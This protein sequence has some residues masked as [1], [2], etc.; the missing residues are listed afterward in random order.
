MAGRTATDEVDEPTQLVNETGPFDLGVQGSGSTE[1]VD[2]SKEDKMDCIMLLHHV[3]MNAI[4]D[5][6][7]IPL[8][9]Q[10]AVTK[11][12]SAIA[13]KWCSTS[14]L[15]AAKEALR[16]TSDNNLH[17]SMALIASKHIEGLLEHKE[18]SD[19]TGDF[20]IKVMKN[21]VAMKEA[22]KTQVR[23][24]QTKVKQLDGKYQQEKTLRDTEKAETE[25]SRSFRDGQLNKLRD[26]A[27]CQN[28]GATFNGYYTAYE[29]V[30][31]KS[32]KCMH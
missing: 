16:I 18:F 24:L 2:G 23:D 4:A 9:R 19:M 15:V 10:L 25:S 26:T 22:I 20:T 32:C 7:D 1:I 11:F 13:K 17:N 8:L 12:E 30:R 5:Y 14:F 31:C 6:Y 29:G 3:R 27:A 28:C 21:M